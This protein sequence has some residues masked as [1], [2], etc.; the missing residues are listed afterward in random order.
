MVSRTGWRRGVAV[1]PSIYAADF[2]SLG[3]QLG[4]LLDAGAS[5]FHFDVGDGHFI[6]E[7]TMGPIVLESI[8]DLVHRRGGVL[9][10]HLMVEQPARHLEHVRAAGGDSV[11]FHI[12]A[13]GEPAATIAQAR[14]L[15]LGVGVAC[16][17]E[18]P[19]EVAA[20][21][22][23][24]T[25]FLLCMSIHPG[26]SGQEFIPESLDRIAEL[27]R[28]LPDE[29]AVQADGGIHLGNIAAVRR[30]GASLLVSGSAV[31]WDDD[32]AAAYHRLVKAAEATSGTR[33]GV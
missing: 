25:D 4:W 7:I 12:E 23:G 17:L 22:A 8:G 13:E 3:A 27:R 21:A 14:D 29:V 1:E 18:T 9:D 2:A 15:G 24:G 20:A 28:L 30:A 10:C 5:V 19:I 32:P 26:L 6:P 31:F 16:N 11:T 33:K